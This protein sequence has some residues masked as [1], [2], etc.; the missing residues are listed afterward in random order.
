MK[1]TSPLRSRR[2]RETVPPLR[3]STPSATGIPASGTPPDVVLPALPAGR[4]RGTP[5]SC[6]W[7]HRGTDRNRREACRADRRTRPHREAGRGS[8][9]VPNGG[10]GRSGCPGL[11]PGVRDRAGGSC[12]RNSRRPRPPI[13]D[14][15]LCTERGRQVRGSDAQRA[16]DLLTRF[17]TGPAVPNALRSQRSTPIAVL[18]SGGGR[19]N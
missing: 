9:Q 7:R 13:L 6:Q 10:R 16:A 11:S 8:D 4:V 2:G 14:V 3:R 19:K 5:R 17:P 18:P 1:R 12:H 15:R